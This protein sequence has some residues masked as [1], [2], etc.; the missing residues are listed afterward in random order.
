MK[1]Q[2]IQYVQ[3]RTLMSLIFHLL[4][5]IWWVAAFVDN[6]RHLWLLRVVKF[7]KGF[8]QFKIQPGFEKMNRLVRDFCFVLFC[9]LS[10][11][12]PR[13]C[14]KAV[15]G[16]SP[17]MTNTPSPICSAELLSL[18]VHKER[19][20]HLCGHF[21]WCVAGPN[22]PAVLHLSLCRSLSR[23]NHQV[24]SC[25]T[26][27]TKIL[28]RGSVRRLLFLW[29]FFFL[30]YRSVICFKCGRFGDCL[31]LD[32]KKGFQCCAWVCG[33]LFWFSPHVFPEGS[34]NLEVR[35]EV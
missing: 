22:L 6:H 7:L 21:S 14:Q 33:C 27:M 20:R 30:P 4:G 1:I 8:G 3:C 28:L 18:S 29:T 35:Q 17:M 26:D 34:W 19:V 24:P 23:R 2:F 15:S 31:K 10:R 9:F 13:K 5:G 16:C 32:Y 12:I 25:S 11:S